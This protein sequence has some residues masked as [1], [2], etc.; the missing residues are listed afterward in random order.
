MC[1]MSE[2]FHLEGVDT[3]C[4]FG[5]CWRTWS[6]IRSKRWASKIWLHFLLRCAWKLL[7]DSTFLLV[8]SRDNLLLRV[9]LTVAGNE[10]M[11]E[12][13]QKHR[14][15]RL[16]PFLARTAVQLVAAKSSVRGLTSAISITDADGT[17]TCEPRLTRDT[18]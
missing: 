7:G 14:T 18:M 8:V 11:L 2:V 10:S 6:P 4:G 5:A 15:P 17:D 1:H 16:R 3:G 12:L 9:M 13:A